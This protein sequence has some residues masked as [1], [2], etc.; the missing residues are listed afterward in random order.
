M[1]E[2]QCRIL[3]TLSIMDKNVFNLRYKTRGNMHFI[4]LFVPFYDPINHCHFDEMQLPLFS[5][6][7]PVPNLFQLPGSL[8][9]NSSFVLHPDFFPLKH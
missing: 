5:K 1:K 2:T 9:N 7:Q 6:N 3:F 4:H 8:Y